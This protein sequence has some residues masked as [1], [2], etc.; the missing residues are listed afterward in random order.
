MRTEPTPLILLATWCALL[1]IDVAAADSADQ[2][3]RV[4]ARKIV[5]AARWREGD[6][7]KPLEIG[8]KLRP[9]VVVRTGRQSRVGMAFP[10]NGIALSLLEDS[11]IR[12]NRLIS[13]KI[14]GRVTCDHGLELKAGQIEAEVTTLAATSKFEVTVPDGVIGVRGNNT[15]FSLAA[16]FTLSVNRGTVVLVYVNKERSGK[17]T[18]V[19]VVSAGEKFNP[20]SLKVE[21]IGK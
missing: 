12:L 14:N 5:G 3:V 11:T 9:G 17:D 1:Q 13:Q 7:W 2:S 19:H 20:V 18:L 6:A 8:E 4:V 10:D 15:R 16:D 21:P